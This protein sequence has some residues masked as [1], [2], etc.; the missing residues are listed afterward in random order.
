[1]GRGDSS[2]VS[3][4][5]FVFATSARQLKILMKLSV[6]IK[7][8]AFSFFFVSQSSCTFIILMQTWDRNVN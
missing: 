4:L 6:F 8:N 2:A 5:H 3:E 7:H 1:M